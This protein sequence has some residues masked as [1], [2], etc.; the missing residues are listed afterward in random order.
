MRDTMKGH[1]VTG[2]DH[3][4]ECC[5]PHAAVFNCSMYGTFNVQ[6]PFLRIQQYRPTIVHGPKRYWFV[7]I[8]EADTGKEYFGWAVRDKTS[9]Q[10]VN[11]LE[12]V[13]KRLLP[14][15]LKSGGLE[16]TILQK[17]DRLKIQDWAKKQYWF[18]TFPFT[19]VKRADSALVWKTIDVISWA[20]LDVL[21]WGCHYGYMGFQ[22]SERGASVLGIDSNKR[23]LNAARIIR[24]HVIQQDVCF[25]SDF[26]ERPDGW[27]VIL[28]LSVHHQR[29]PSYRRLGETVELLRLMARK[30]VFVELILPPTFPKGVKMGVQQIDEAVGGEQLLNYKHAVRG[31]RK[32]YHLEVER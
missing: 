21:D 32:I 18:Q 3:A 17:W 14:D 5:R 16:V 9:K 8:V 26:G 13:T 22:A 6:V 23:S 7:R 2:A 20:G 25:A 31:E 19:P 29:D 12:V 1:Y 27:D 10:R 15:S 24:N 28:Y 30:H 4:H 11:T